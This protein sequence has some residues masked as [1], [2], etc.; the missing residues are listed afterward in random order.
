MRPRWVLLAAAAI[1]ALVVGGLV[2]NN[3]VTDRRQE[4]EAAAVQSRENEYL[5]RLIANE[6]VGIGD[7]FEKPLDYGYEWCS[8]PL[9]TVRMDAFREKTAH[10]FGWQRQQ[11]VS[12]LNTA[13]ATLCQ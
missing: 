5:N 12:M 9:D 3:Y 8:V 1:A 6:I 11:A 13:D 2:V 10:A 4:R 7:D